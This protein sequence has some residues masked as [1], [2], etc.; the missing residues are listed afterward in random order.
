MSQTQAS[1]KPYDPARLSAIGNH[2]TRRL[3]A[4]PLIQAVD[5]LDAQVYLYPAFLN[6]ADCQLLMDTIDKV[7]RPSTLYQGT[8][9]EGFRTSYSG[10]VDSTD[11]D[12]VRIETR[13]CKVLGVERE[14]A[15][16]LQGQR[17]QVGQEFKQHHDFF[18]R[19]E[20]YWEEEAP[21]GGQRSWT[22]MVFLNEPEEGGA[23][24][25]PNLGIS[26][27]PQRGMM[28]IW[29]NMTPDGKENWQTLHAATPVRKGVKYVITKWFRQNR[30]CP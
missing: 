30:Y 7:A 8:E 1:E 6:A 13:I 18:H 24:E 11:P 23:T 10:D 3:N 15:E 26:I 25:F 9:Q 21:R 22:A 17:Y 19:G 20:P 2:V 27:K 29:N 4:N 14:R 12:I 16:T 28:L 5:V